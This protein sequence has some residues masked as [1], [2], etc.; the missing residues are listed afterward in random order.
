MTET[1][2]IILAAGI[3]SRMNTKMAKVL[4]EVCG[5]PMLAYVLD[6]CRQAGI[7]KM[8]V[9][10]GFDSEQVK[11]RFAGAQDVVW[12]RQDEQLGTGHAVLC[13]K[14]H[15]Q[16]FQGQTLVLCGDGPLIRSQTLTKLLKE[17]EAGHAAATLAI[18]FLTIVFFSRH[19]KT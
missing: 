1:V 12:V 4:H 17:H 7:K 19:S 5:R 11:E 16:D 6:A 18:I 8:Y 14:E 15:L 3:S 2:S 10:V 13:C 9:V